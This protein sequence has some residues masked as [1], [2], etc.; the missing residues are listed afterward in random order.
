M[1]WPLVDNLLFHHNVL[2][3]VV[4]YESEVAAENLRIILKEKEGT[5]EEL[6]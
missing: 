3:K 4:M 6:V 2:E 5:I 1:T